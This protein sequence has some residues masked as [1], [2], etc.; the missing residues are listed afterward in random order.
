MLRSENFI[1]FFTVSGFFIGLIFSI[2]N[3][4]TPED[5]LIYTGVVTFSFY[6]FIH[7]V[8]MNFVDIKRFGVGLFNKKEH[9]NVNEYFITELDSREKAMDNLLLELEKMNFKYEKSLHNSSEQKG[10]EHKKAH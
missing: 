9:E 1:Y 10:S 5:I 7:I 6:I 2:L 3:F 4:S 8:V